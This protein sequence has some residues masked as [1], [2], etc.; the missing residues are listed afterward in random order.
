[1]IDAEMKDTLELEKEVLDVINDG[2]K[3]FGALFPTTRVIYNDPLNDTYRNGYGRMQFLGFMADKYIEEEYIFFFDSDAFLHTYADR[4]DFWENGKPIISGRLSYTNHDLFFKKTYD[5][6]GKEEIMSCMSY[7]PI[8]I[9]RSHL[10]PIRE[11]IREYR[12][13]STF[14]EAYY[15]FT[16]G[17]PGAQYNIMCTWLFLNRRDEYAWRLKDLEPEWDGFHKPKPRPGMWADKSIYKPGEIK[18]TVP[19]LSEHL[20]YGLLRHKN[21]TYSGG[22]WGRDN[23]QLTR[24]ILKTVFLTSLCYLETQQP[25]TFRLASNTTELG[26]WAYST[27]SHFCPEFVKSNYYHEEWWRFEANNFKDV[28]D[29]EQKQLIKQGRKQRLKN[30]NH[31]YMLV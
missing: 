7:F 29:E 4:E 16:L 17:N 24:R 11:A 20:T 23:S 25:Y 26:K 10:A 18:F 30:C 31:T 5:A 21:G 9:K 1:M 28:L 13:K 2:R 3:D 6:L 27:Y 19:Y 14:E 15:D 22:P 12:N 8:L